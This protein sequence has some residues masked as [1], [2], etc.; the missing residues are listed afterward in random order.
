[1]GVLAFLSFFIYICTMKYSKNFERDYEWYFKYKNIFTFDANIETN[2]FIISSPDGENAKY[3]FYKKDSE[4][5][6]IP[7]REPDILFK[8]LKCKGSIN[9][10]IKEWAI[11]RGKGWLGYKEFEDIIKEFELLDWM[12]DAVENQKYKY[13]EIITSI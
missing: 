11:D 7:T 6:V 12:I 13:T 4:G 9:F 10:Q 5:K 1:M 3:C 8:L 2:K